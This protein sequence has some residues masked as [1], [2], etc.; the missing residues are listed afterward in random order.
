MRSRLS[1]LAL[2]LG[3]AAWIAA[4]IVAPAAAQSGTAPFRVEITP[5]EDGIARRE[6]D[7]I[8]DAI[9]EAHHEL[10]PMLQPLDVKIRISRRSDNAEARY[11]VEM[12]TPVQL[13]LHRDAKTDDQGNVTV[14]G[15]DLVKNPVFDRIVAM[16]EYGHLVMTANASVRFREYADFEI[17]QSRVDAISQSLNAVF[18]QKDKLSVAMKS[19]SGAQSAKLQAQLDALDAQ[20]TKLS[21]QRDKLMDAIG[22]SFVAHNS[23]AGLKE[24]FADVVAVAVTGDPSAVRRAMAFAGSSKQ[25][26]DLALWRDFSR[27]IPLERWNQSDVHVLY[28]PTR[29]Y[30]GSRLLDDPRFR[31]DP[32]KLVQL[33]Y[34]AVEAELDAVRKRGS[35]ADPS[36]E[37]LNR[38][39]IARLEALA[40]Q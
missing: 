24:L 32:Y 34:R 22:S 14:R 10:E 31:H 28:S 4:G 19:A 11:F 25:E 3:F 1:H 12:E 7:R 6:T 9:I 20:A 40:A 39:L 18:A 33:V 30:I 13:V 36:P 16:H 26:R 38:A 21:A 37:A 27:R 17:N 5:I 35:A 29:A 15:R 2:C 8:R 23:V